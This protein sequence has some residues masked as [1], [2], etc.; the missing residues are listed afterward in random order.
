MKS[1]FKI[2]VILGVSLLSKG[3]TLQTLN[4]SIRV[5][6][7][8][9]PTKSEF[10][11]T[12]FHEE[13]DISM[14]SLQRI[15]RTLIQEGLLERDENTKMYSLGL[16][17]YFLG[18]LVEDQSQLLSISKEYMD[19]LNN[20]TNETVTL[21][22]INQNQRKC[23]GYVL[24]KHELTTLSY[25]SSSSP[26][27]AGASA[28]VLLAFLPDKEIADYLDNSTLESV[29]ENTTTD[30]AELINELKAI[31]NSGYSV[32][33][34][35]RVLGVCAISAPIINRFGNVIASMTLT[36]PSVRVNRFEKDN[37][38]ELVLKYASLISEKLE[39]TG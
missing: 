19:Q 14:S 28:K 10:T 21:N 38:I 35:E 22:I 39:Y 25:I 33:E 24:A 8:F 9:T 30:R 34:S 17:L 7:L 32:T 2:E 18:K 16:E 11:L 15:L 4:R 36:I 23:I 13:L 20:E 12:E 26:L 5:L 29:T 3:D 27:Y 37:Y 1:S 31:K 6:K